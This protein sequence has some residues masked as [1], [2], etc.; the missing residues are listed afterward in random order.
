M[1]TPLASVLTIPTALP[2]PLNDAATASAQDHI[3]LR[4]ASEFTTQISPIT[5]VDGK[6]KLGLVRDALDQPLVFSIGNGEVRR[7]YEC[8]HEF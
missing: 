6:H 7:T 3:G 2:F 1:S 5:L 4:V 8:L